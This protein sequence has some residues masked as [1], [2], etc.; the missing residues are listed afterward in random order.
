M[1]AQFLFAHCRAANWTCALAAI[2]GARSRDWTLG[3]WLIPLRARRCAPIRHSDPT[4]FGRKTICSVIGLAK[5]C[6]ATGAKLLT[7]SCSSV[8]DG[9]KPLPYVESDTPAPVGDHG[10][11]KVE[12]ERAALE[13]APS[14]LIVRSGVLFG[15]WDLEKDVTRSLLDPAAGGA[16]YADERPI[17]FSYLPDLANASLDLLIDDESGLWHLANTGQASPHELVRRLEDSVSIQSTLEN[18]A[19]GGL[20]TAPHP[21]YCA[22]GSERASLMP[23][24]ESALQRYACDAPS[25]RMA[26]LA[27]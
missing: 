12:E 18:T 23:S 3:R 21:L 4:E 6:A 8:F 22:L 26:D 1:S 9:T 25:E 13:N 14:T 27:A 2:W 24:L 17:S 10:R 19:P 20:S 11:L 15:P 5:E 7:F 16:H